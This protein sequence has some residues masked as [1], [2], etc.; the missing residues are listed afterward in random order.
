MSG[1]T[2]AA[3]TPEIN[4]TAITAPPTI[5][6]PVSDR[7]IFAIIQQLPAVVLAT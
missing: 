6:L 3:H 5:R 2:M 7:S 4:C 1:P